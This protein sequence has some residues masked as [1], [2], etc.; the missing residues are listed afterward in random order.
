MADVGVVGVPNEKSGEVPRAYVVPVNK[1]VKGEELQAFVASKFARH[2]HLVGGVKFVKELPKNQ[3]G[4]L[5][6]IELKK[7]ASRE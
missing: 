4:K 1:E 7:M 5:L 3:T 2:K 6:R